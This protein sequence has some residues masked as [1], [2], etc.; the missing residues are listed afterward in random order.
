MNPSQE[1]VLQWNTRSLLSHWGQFKHYI[2]SNN[3][4]AAAVQETHFNDID[5]INYTYKIPGFSL[6]THNLNV[7]PR[8][9]GSALL[10]SNNLLHHQIDLPPALD[11]VGVKIKIAQLD[12]TLI[13]IYLRPSDNLDITSIANLFKNVDNPCLIMGDFNSHHQAWGCNTTTPRGQIMLNL[14]DQHNLIFLNDQSPTHIHHHQGEA[15]YS[16]IDLAITSPRTAPLFSFQ[17]QSD[18]FFSDHFP[19]HIELQVP[20][21]QTNFFSLPRWNLRRADWSSFQHLI[22]ESL[23]PNSHP[24][25]NTFLNTILTSAH[26]H[27]PHTQHHPGRRSSPWWNTDCQRAVA[28]RK[29]A[30][31]KFQ[32]YVC[33]ANEKEARRT[34]SLANQIIRKAKEDSWKE[35][36]SQFNR[37]T[38]LSKIWSMLK[39]FSNKRAPVYKI[40]HLHINNTSFMLPPEVATEFAKHY[41]NISSTQQCTPPLI[42]LLNEQIQ[43]INFESNNNETYNALFTSSEL[44]HALNK[45][46]KTSVG[47]DQIDY[48]FFRNLSDIG[49]NNLLSAFNSLWVEGTFPDAWHDSTLIPILKPRK[50]PSSPSSY[51]PISLTSCACKL[52]ERMINVRIRTYLEYNDIISPFQ[53]GFR[54][55]RSTADNLVRLIDSVQ[56]GFQQKEITLALFLDL[57]AAFDRVNKT[58]LLIKIHKCGIRGRLATFIQNFL[59]KRTF[60]VRCGNTYSPS[61]N[62]DHG[63]PQG[64]VIS[65]TLFIIMINDIFNDI[66]HINQQIK[67]SM[68]A[69]DLVVWYTHPSVDQANRILQLVVNKIELWCDQWGLEVSPK[70]SAALIFSKKPKYVKPYIP[71]QLKDQIIPVVKTYK[72]LGITLDSGLNFSPH[73]KD[74]VQRC[75]RRINIIKSLAGRDWGADRST[76]LN[77]Y[78]S[79]IRPILDYNG[80]LFD[81]ISSPKIKTL[82]TVQNAALRIVTGALRTSNAHNLHIDT[83]IPL[84]CH[85]RKYQLMRF[86]ANS[87]T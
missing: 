6:Y 43:T 31:R 41:S 67:L 81:D 10:I 3:P 68:Y 51:R 46:G 21:G 36:S 28:I 19:I 76:L 44:S 85:R 79:L 2:L 39:S 84:L 9:G 20:S 71:L 59:D 33:E 8:R 15:S 42:H 54:P 13:S 34:R 66:H 62:Q 16:A 60:K 56:R 32:K 80:F 83:N 35:Y 17:A 27:I 49:F 58:A 72:Y 26:Q 75:T 52:L 25:I 18:P 40:P 22:D 1:F 45:C 29:R 77:L 47:P 48:S 50:P 5:L 12:L 24:D 69:D 70:K 65:P 30:L 73:F 11:A 53:S 38:P 78:T 87:T 4:L 14:M 23:P 86:Y 55:G 57:R 74:I 64:S 7:T 61:F 37:F 63:V 82:Q